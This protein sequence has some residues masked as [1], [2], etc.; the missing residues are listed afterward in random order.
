MGWKVY[1]LRG[2]ILCVSPSNVV[3]TLR[4]ATHHEDNV[5]YGT[6]RNDSF[7][8]GLLEMTIHRD[9]WNEVKKESSEWWLYVVRCSDD[10]LYTGIT[11]DIDRRLHEHNNT[12]RG[13]KYTRGRRPVELVYKERY[14]NLREAQRAEHK[15]K[16]LA[17][18]E[19]LIKIRE[20]SLNERGED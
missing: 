12:S 5:V 10:T 6:V 7:N 4:V 20:H 19:K 17:R 14:P 13:A 2:F 11:K 15:F 3:A 8:S 18:H 1:C 16:W 9:M